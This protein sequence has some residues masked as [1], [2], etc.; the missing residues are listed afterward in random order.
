MNGVL[1]KLGSPGCMES[2]ITSHPAKQEELHSKLLSTSWNPYGYRTPWSTLIHWMS[3]TLWLQSAYTAPT[4]LPSSTLVLLHGWTTD[5]WHTQ[6]ISRLGNGHNS[7]SHLFEAT[8]ETSPHTLAASSHCLNALPS[9][10]A[11]FGAG[12]FPY[13][14]MLVTIKELNFQSRGSY[15][16]FSSPL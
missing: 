12:Q 4:A 10:P 7:S 14:A 6:P 16:C 3:R 8:Q 5:K 11:R 9:A 1:N 2:P 13:E 15:N